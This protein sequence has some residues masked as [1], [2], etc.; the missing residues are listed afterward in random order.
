MQWGERLGENGMCYKT[1]WYSFWYWFLQTHSQQRQNAEGKASLHV[2][3]S[4]VTEKNVS[5]SGVRLGENDTCCF[6]VKQVL[7]P[8]GSRDE[9]E[10]KSYK[11]REK[12]RQISRV[13]I[14]D[15]ATTAAHYFSKFYLLHRITG[16]QSWVI[17]HAYFDS[18]I[19]SILF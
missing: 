17:I 11:S 10:E 2:F 6:I 9:G 13:S 7:L 4:K 8:Q 1:I 19:N 12:R 15:T 16:S 14:S 18:W 3:H 5:C